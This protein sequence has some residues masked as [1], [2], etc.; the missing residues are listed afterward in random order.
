MTRPYGLMIMALSTFVQ[1]CP[2][3]LGHCYQ[4][5]KI[6]YNGFLDSNFDGTPNQFSPLAQ[7]YATSKIDN[8]VCHLDEILRQP[9][10]HEFMKY[11]QKEVEAMFKQKIWKRVPK[12]LMTDYYK[13]ELQKG[14]EPKRQQ[15]SVI[16]SFKRKRKPDGTLDKYKARLCCHGG[17]QEWGINY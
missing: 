15:L 11:M 14:I 4:A 2:G 9:N 10:K 17:Q 7:I 3:T 5:R 8:E 6:A 13:R 16:W 12:K 1:S